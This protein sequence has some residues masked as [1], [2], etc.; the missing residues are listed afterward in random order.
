MSQSQLNLSQSLKKLES[1]AEWFEKQND[2]D[3]EVAL[4]K[5][6]ESAILI[7]ESRN[8]L[9]RIENTFEEIQKDLEKE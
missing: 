6:K 8:R 5:I 4:E 3:I 1:I 7:K 2:I 9:K